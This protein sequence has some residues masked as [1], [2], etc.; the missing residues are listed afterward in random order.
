MRRRR[1]WTHVRS[2]S[3]MNKFDKRGQRNGGLSGLGRE[4]GRLALDDAGVDTARSSRIRRYCYGDPRRAK[5]AVYGLRAHRIPSGAT[6]NNNDPNGYSA[7]Y[8]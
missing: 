6:S 1:K 5:R 8:M 3:G 7:L 2:R 4:A